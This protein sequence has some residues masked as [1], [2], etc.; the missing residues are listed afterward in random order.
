MTSEH[1]LDLI[2]ERDDDVGLLAAEPLTASCL[3]P[4]TQLPRATGGCRCI[5]TLQ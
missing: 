3:A 5:P 4:W 2:S 1:I